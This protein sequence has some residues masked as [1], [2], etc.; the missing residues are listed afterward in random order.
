MGTSPH[1]NFCLWLG[2]YGARS[3]TLGNGLVPRATW[4]GIELAD[5]CRFQCQWHCRW[6]YFAFGDA[7]HHRLGHCLFTHAMHWPAVMGNTSQTLARDWASG[8]SHLMHDPFQ[9]FFQHSHYPKSLATYSIK[10]ASPCIMDWRY[11]VGVARTVLAMRLPFP[12]KLARSRH[13]GR[14]DCN[15]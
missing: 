1:C 13:F 15:F 8:C 10:N 7:L 5:V 11:L 9:L 12:E 2:C 6:S 4:H 14:H 3:N